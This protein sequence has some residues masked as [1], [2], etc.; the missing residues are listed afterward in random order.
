MRNYKDKY[1]RDLKSIEIAQ[2]MLAQEAR[3]RTVCAWTGLKRDRVQ[4]LVRTS[5][6]RS[7][8]QRHRGP[9]PSRLSALLCTTRMRD[10]AA[11]AAGLC[12][13]LQILPERATPGARK[14]FPNPLR[15]ERLL[16]AFELFR[17]AV[18]Q[19]R[20]TLEHLV[21][22]VLTLAEGDSWA[23]DHCTRCHATILIDTLGVA[24]RRLC[25]YCGSTETCDVQGAI[26]DLLP[27]RRHEREGAFVQQRLFD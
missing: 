11:A 15:A 10:E 20:L 17:E 4:N 8:A 1:T 25:T 3:T 24:P 6:R 22:V 5:A 23:I 7:D 26:G 18:P 9:S 12:R 14:D 2:R 21:L 13:V 27:A 19:A 16:K